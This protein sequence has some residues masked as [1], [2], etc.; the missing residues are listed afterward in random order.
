M[1]AISFEILKFTGNNRKELKDISLSDL[2]DFNGAI[3]YCTPDGT[4]VKDEVYNL[5]V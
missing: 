3:N 5:E 4:F 1:A 2:S